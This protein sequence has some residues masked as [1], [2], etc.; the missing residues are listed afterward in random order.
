MRQ[1]DGRFKI[2][3]DLGERED[4]FTPVDGFVPSLGM[5]AVVFDHEQF[6]HTFIG[7]HLSFK[8]ASDDVG[9]ALGFER[10]LF[11]SRKLYVGGEL[12]DLTRATTSWQLSANEASI[13]AVAGRRSFRDYYERRGVQIGGA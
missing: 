6:N 3:P 2:V 9:Y 8:M 11:G 13:A 5:G 4:W 10:P 12:H 7:G 1:P